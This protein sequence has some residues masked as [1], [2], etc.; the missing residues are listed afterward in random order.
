VSQLT[1]FL[2]KHKK[3][4]LT[5]VRVI[6]AG[7]TRG[8]SEKV[9]QNLKG[10]G[11]AVKVYKGLTKRPAKSEA[12][13]QAKAAAVSPP[14]IVGISEAKAQSMPGGKRIPGLPQTSGTTTRKRA[15]VAAVKQS[16]SARKK[17]AAKPAAKGGKRTAPSGGKDFKAL[18]ASWKKAGKPGKWIDWVKSH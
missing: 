15:R 11:A 10:I 9:V 7:V 3:A 16:K 12:A 14:K 17:A 8:K 2:K 6:A 1:R 13:V 18:S 4:V 5:G